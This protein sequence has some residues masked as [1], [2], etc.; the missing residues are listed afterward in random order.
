MG[1]HSKKPLW[2]TCNAIHL[3]SGMSLSKV[4]T[5]SRRPDFPKPR[6]PEES[7]LVYNWP[8]V[9]EHFQTHTKW[10]KAGQTELGLSMKDEMTALDLEVKRSEAALRRGELVKKKEVVEA[11]GNLNAELCGMFK[12]RYVDEMPSKCLGKNEVECRI[13]FETAYNEVIAAFRELL[14]KAKKQI[15]P[16]AAT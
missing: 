8:E 7:P 12:Q 10:A 16:K 14:Q 4:Q 5:H 15:E 9:E 1:K 13:L 2:L 3:K 6:D 11:F